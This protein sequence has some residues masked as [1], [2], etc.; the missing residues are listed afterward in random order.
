M[1]VPRWVPFAAVAFGIVEFTNIALEQFIGLPAP[2]NAIVPAS[3]MAIIVLTASTVAVRASVL[4]AVIVVEGGMLLAACGALLW[5]AFAR[6][7][8]AAAGSH[9]GS[10][11]PRAAAMGHV[12][13]RALRDGARDAAVR[14]CDASYRFTFMTSSADRNVFASATASP[15]PQKCMKNNR[16]CSFSM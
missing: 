1:R 6:R 8:R 12:R 11:A 15:L 14:D 13:L 9:V 3:A 7:G 2:W 4:S 5:A 10:A 16:G